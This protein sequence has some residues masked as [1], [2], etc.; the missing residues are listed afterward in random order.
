YIYESNGNAYVFDD[1]KNINEIK[2]GQNASFIF[3][4]CEYLKEHNNERFLEAAQKVAN[5][6]L[7]M[8]D[9][10]TWD[11]THVLNYPDLP[12]KEKFRIVY[13][14]GEAALAL[15][16]LYQQDHNEQWLNTVKSLVD[17]FIA[18]DYWKYHDHWLGYCT[19]E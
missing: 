10:N 8:I 3:A 5:G 6:I 16:R 11:T 1:T 9:E 7:T 13:Y 17:Q 2:L 15:M 14:D 12:V 4:V 18:K 19:N